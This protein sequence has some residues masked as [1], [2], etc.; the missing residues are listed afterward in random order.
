MSLAVAMTNTGAVLSESQVRKVPKT[1]EAV[2]PSLPAEPC[3]PAKALSISS[4][5]RIA[6]ATLSAVW[7]GAPHR[8]FVEPTRLPNTRPMSNR[9][10][11][12]PQAR[13]RLGAEALYRIPH[14]Q[15]QHPPAPAG[16]TARLAR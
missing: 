15:E 12:F 1:L 7:M 11:Q 4:I 8:F 10:G 3:V 9:A 5:Q 6:G 13:C 16:R 2:P 14:A